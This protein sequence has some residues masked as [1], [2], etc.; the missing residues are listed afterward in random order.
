MDDETGERIKQARVARGISQ[1]ELAASVG[2]SNSYL[3]HI[4][5]GRRPVSEPIRLQVAAALG[6]DPRQLEE[7]VPAD[8]KE[9][10]RLNLS[11]AEMALRNGNWELAKTTFEAALAS[12]RAMPL[13]RFVDEA[14]W[15]VARSLETTG[16]LEDAISAYEDLLSRPTL[17]AGV[18]RV[19]V[20]VALVRAYRE[21]GDLAR[22]ID[23]GER[24]LGDPAAT[25]ATELGPHVELIAALAGCY[26]ERGDLTRA[27]LLSRRALELADQGGSMQARAAAAW[28]A[29]AVAQSRHDSVAARLHADRALALYEE[30]DNQRAVAMLRVVSAA[31]FL[32]QDQ[33]DPGKALPLLE[34]AFEELSEAGNDVDLAYLRTEQ[35]RAELL[36]GHVDEAATIAARALAA[37]S[38]GDKLQRGRILLL[39]GHVARADGRPEDALASFHDAADHLRQAGAARQAATAW[40]ELGE[41]Y[42]ALGRP[43]EAIDAMRQASDL[44]G[45]RLAPYSLAAVGYAVRE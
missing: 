19:A 31:L 14:L 11:F 26:V 18:S 2:V 34:R 37:L 24:R 3:S 9:E 22:A 33:P 4:E 32:R 25:P 12:A 17:S 45:V 8:R 36:A 15:G 39:Q 29:A 5:A 28:E 38:N 7:G 16:R 27:A 35:A 30:L 41:A 13:E 1:A 6:L 42:V 21:C 20:G 10:L 44:V 40:R 43:E 23:V